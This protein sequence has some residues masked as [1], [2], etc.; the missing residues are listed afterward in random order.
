MTTAVTTVENWQIAESANVLREDLIVRWVNFVDRTP[1][2]AKAYTAA[3]KR[4][5]R[6]LKDNGIINPSREDVISYR[7]EMSKSLK[8]ASVKLNLN[9]VKLFFE[10]L[11]SEG[12]YRNI[13]ANVHAPKVMNET[14]SRAAL[15][16]SESR[17]VLANL[18]DNSE[19]NLRDK[20]IMLLMLVTGLRSVE[21]T[22]LDIGDIEQR[23]GKNFLRVHGK[24]RAGKLDLVPLPIELKNLIDSYISKYRKNA[25][26]TAPLFV[27]TSHR[28]KGQRL[29]TQ[30]ISR[31][32]KKALNSAGFTAECYTC[33]SM[34]HSYATIALQHG[35]NLRDI[36]K[37]L[38]HRNQSITEVYLHDNNLLNNQ[39]TSLV[40]SILG[41]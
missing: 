25:K 21:V 40:A 19:K 6:F 31:N 22:R 41:L 38:R 27:S 1:A 8:P 10:W 34:R 30:T 15:T 3:V 9:A 24:A 32:A 20:C 35:A 4:F 33:H 16:E 23:Q 11:S 5:Y 28:C 13:S 26:K 18:R 7:D 2:T 14:H 17:A 36:S 39:T 12:F 37:V 29:Q